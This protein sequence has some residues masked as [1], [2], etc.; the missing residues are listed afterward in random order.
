MGRMM[1][2]VGTLKRQ[3]PSRV[4]LP[5]AGCYTA[6][7]HCG[8]DAT[9]SHQVTTGYSDAAH[10]WPTEHIPMLRNCLKVPAG[11]RL[12]PELSSRDVAG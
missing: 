11:T 10:V 3:C 6:R 1:K 7:A 9:R 2:H 8:K 4:Q 5:A 12:I